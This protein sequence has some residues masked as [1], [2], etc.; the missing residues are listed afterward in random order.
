M[1]LPV[2]KNCEQEEFQL[3]GV[4]EVILN[5]YLVEQ[6]LV[7]AKDLVYGIR[8]QFQIPTEMSHRFT[9][10][11]EKLEGYDLQLSRILGVEIAVLI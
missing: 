3:L 10:S 5:E 4:N 6:S 8:I 9:C 2:S 1:I 11:L 7:L